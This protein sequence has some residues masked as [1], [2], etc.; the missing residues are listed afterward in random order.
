M[1]IS[2]FGRIAAAGAVTVALLGIGAGVANADPG[3]AQ[4]DGSV[5]AQQCPPPPGNQPGQPPQAP[6]PDGQPPQCPQ[7]N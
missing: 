4:P 3:P 6:Q 7:A 2:R 1:A 5:P